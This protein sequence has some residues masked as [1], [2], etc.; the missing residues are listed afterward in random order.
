MS[1]APQPSMP[2]TFRLVFTLALIS[3]LSGVTIVGAYQITRAPIARNHREAL[4]QDGVFRVLPGAS[5]TVRYRAD[6]DGLTRIDDP[7]DESANVYA[8]YDDGELIGVAMEGSAEGYGGS[9][10]VLFGYDPEEETVIGYH[11]LESSETPGLGERIRDDEDFLANFESLELPLDSEDEALAQDVQVVSP[12][13]ASE[14][15]EIDNI[16]GA[17]VSVEAVATAI[18]RSAERFLPTIVQNRERIREGE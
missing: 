17:T 15:G 7:V 14:P 16:T 2:S 4:E 3:M 10:R 9:V 6:D 5:S 18:Q 12:G 8:G 1:D 13:S 11:V